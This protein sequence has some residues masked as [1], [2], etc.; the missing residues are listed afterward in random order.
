[1]PTSCLVSVIIPVYNGAN[2]LPHVFAGLARQTLDPAQFEVIVTDDCSTDSTPELLQG[3]VNQTL[4]SLTILKQDQ[5][6][7]ASAARNLAAKAA[8]GDYLLFIDA[9][10]V[11]DDHLLEC[12]LTAQRLQGGTGIVGRIVWSAEFGGGPVT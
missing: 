7:G 11:P 10:C 8:K 2:T 12:H 5:N 4:F 9:D 6:W 3:Y 1:M